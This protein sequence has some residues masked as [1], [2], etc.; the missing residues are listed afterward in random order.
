MG[1]SSSLFLITELHLL[2]REY[3]TVRS[4][5]HPSLM[6]TSMLMD[7]W[8]PNIVFFC[9]RS[10]WLFNVPGVKPHAKKQLVPFEHLCCGPDGRRTLVLPREANSCSSA[11]RA[12]AQSMYPRSN[13][14]SEPRMWTHLPWPCYFRSKISNSV[15]LEPLIWKKQ[16]MKL[17]NMCVVEAHSVC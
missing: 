12:Y 9:N 10:I 17:Y 15:S 13:N 3:S 8:D 7:I 6:S 1:K 5:P 2:P 16:K 14:L 11:G 4:A